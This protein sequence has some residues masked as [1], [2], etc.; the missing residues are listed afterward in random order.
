MS[1][2]RPVLFAAMSALILLMMPRSAF[3]VCE[4]EVRAWASEI[5]YPERAQEFINATNRDFN[6]NIK[7][8][9]SLD[10]AIRSEH[11]TLPPGGRITAQ[12][13][14]HI[15]IGNALKAVR[16]QQNMRP[17]AGQQGAPIHA[18]TGFENLCLI[19]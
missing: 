10:Q 7:S 9:S 19:R 18:A 16:D 17:S 2:R 14:L 3:A 5:G 15:C 13:A 1:Q 6:E 8:P 4:A 11:Y 12:Y